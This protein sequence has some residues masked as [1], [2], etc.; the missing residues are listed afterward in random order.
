M[1][2]AVLDVPTPL[3]LLP[4][5]PLLEVDAD[6]WQTRVLDDRST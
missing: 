5:V 3:T 6:R 4:S 2:T 1:T